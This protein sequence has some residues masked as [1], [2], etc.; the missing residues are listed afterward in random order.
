MSQQGDDELVRDLIGR[1][2]QEALGTGPLAEMRRADPRR[3][4]EAP[5]ALHRLLARL[6][7]DMT[8][9]RQFDRWA[10]LV[11]LLALAAPEQHRGG[12]S[13][14]QALFSAEYSEGRLTRLLEATEADYPVVLPR[15]VRFLVA[16]GERLNPFELAR[17][18]L[19]RDKT[20]QRLRIARDY[21]RAEARQPATA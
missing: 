13:L 14:G 8:R 11:H 2:G 16:H 3:P 10:L 1:L 21:Y 17:L 15:M 18:V 12:Q 7:D 9:G 5:P 4:A 19:R 20:Q 6:P